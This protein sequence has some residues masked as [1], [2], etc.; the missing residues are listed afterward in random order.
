MYNKAYRSSARVKKYYK[1]YFRAYR[2]KNNARTN[3]ISRDSRKNTK[4]K[5]FEQYGGCYCCWC[6]EDD[7][8]VL[9]LDHIDN[10]GAKQRKLLQINGGVTFY[11]WLK[12][13]NYPPGYQ[14]L[15]HNCNMAKQYNNGILPSNRLNKYPKNS[16]VVKDI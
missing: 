12:K 10:N 11:N 3:T 15:C 4:I 8:T 7:L 5:T 6:N 2:A 1:H 16:R 9:T 13:N 14:V